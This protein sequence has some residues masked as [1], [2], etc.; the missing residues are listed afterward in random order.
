M[1]LNK[2]DEQDERKKQKSE[3]KKLLVGSLEFE[4][5]ICLYVL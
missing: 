5:N 4:L 2:N 1:I 3:E